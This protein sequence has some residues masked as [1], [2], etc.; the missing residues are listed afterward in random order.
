M[1]DRAEHRDLPY[2]QPTGSISADEN[3]QCIEGES[4]ST[5]YH[6]HL[7]ILVYTPT[8]E[9]ALADLVYSQDQL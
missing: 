3:E 5:A 2:L 6:S 7:L 8:L 4:D 9:E 1:R